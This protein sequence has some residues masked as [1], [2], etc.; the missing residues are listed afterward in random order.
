M[1]EWLGRYAELMSPSD[2]GAIDAPSIYDHIGSWGSSDQN[3]VAR[4]LQYGYLVRSTMGVESDVI[5]GDLDPI[6]LSAAFSDG[7][8]A[9]R[10]DLAYY[11]AIHSLELPAD[12]LCY[13]T[14]RR[15]V[16]PQ[17]SLDDAQ[18]MM[19]DFGGAATRVGV[20]EWEFLNRR[21][22]QIG[23]RFVAE[24]EPAP[25]D[26]TD[27]IHRYLTVAYKER[28]PI[29]PE[30]LGQFRRCLSTLE[31]DDSMTEDVTILLMLLEDR[32]RYPLA[33]VQRL[34]WPS[35]RPMTWMGYGWLPRWYSYLEGASISIP[36]PF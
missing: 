7:Q 4:Y 15:Y 11:V 34:R 29:V 2:L 35:R 31:M 30:F 18:R 20:T 19:R 9:W 32:V 26:Q 24:A 5:T 8:W 27:E 3:Q 13:V 28:W 23:Y 10:G 16:V 25:E 1:V 14:E 33:L 22:S 12:F 21:I 6:G 36:N 17:V